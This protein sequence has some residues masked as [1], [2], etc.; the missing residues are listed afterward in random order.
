[1]A[2]G[3]ASRAALRVHSWWRTLAGP[4]RFALRVLAPFAGASGAADWSVGW[5]VA[6]LSAQP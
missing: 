6:L 4:T 5:L 2:T 3:S 1:M